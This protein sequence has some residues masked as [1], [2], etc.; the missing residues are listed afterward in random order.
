MQSWDVGMYVFGTVEGVVDSK[1]TSKRQWLTNRPRPPAIGIDLG[2]KDL[3]TCSDGVQTQKPLNLQK[4]EQK[5]G[6]AQRAKKKNVSKRF[7]PKLLI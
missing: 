3:A 1:K 7:M 6:I 4:Y 5:L 2:L